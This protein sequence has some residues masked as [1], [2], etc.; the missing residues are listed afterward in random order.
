MKDQKKK[1]KETVSNS[2]EIEYHGKKHL[3]ENIFNLN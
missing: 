2:A 1:K 3:T